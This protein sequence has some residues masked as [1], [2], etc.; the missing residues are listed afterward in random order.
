MDEEPNLQLLMDTI[1]NCLLV[2]SHI[3]QLSVLQ[4]TQSAMWFHWT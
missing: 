1:I 3:L 4:K 2:D